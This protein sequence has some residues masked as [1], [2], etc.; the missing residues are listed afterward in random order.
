MVAIVGP[1]AVGKTRL[2]LALAEEFGGEII[3]ADSRQVY[4]GMDVGTAKATVEER[5]KVI[6]H[7]LDIRNPDAVSYTHLTL[8]TILL[9]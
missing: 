8:P 4:K 9:V 1:T 7:L 2:S 6:H 3:N 5:S